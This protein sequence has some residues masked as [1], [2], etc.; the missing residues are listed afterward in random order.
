[1]NRQDWFRLLLILLIPNLLRHVSYFMAYQQ[2][3]IYPSISPESVEIFT[4]GKIL[5]FII[6]ELILSGIM[7]FFYFF[8]WRTRFLTFGYLCDSL[9]DMINSAWVEI[10]NAIL[11]NN[12]IIRE[13]FIPYIV[14][15]GIL[16]FKIK[17]YKKIVPVVYALNLLFL[18]IQFWQ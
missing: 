11:M 13:L 6:E 15:G 4:R 17:D 12:F 18:L 1:M 8:D 5:I 14:I 9:I 3:G 10:N 16:M 2:T 7:S